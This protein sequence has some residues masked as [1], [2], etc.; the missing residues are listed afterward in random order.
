MDIIPLKH[1]SI[2]GNTNILFAVDEKSAYV[3]CVGIKSKGRKTLAAAMIEIIHTFNAYGH[4]VTKIISDDESC[5]HATEK[6]MAPLGIEL[7][8]TPAGFHQ[9]RAKRYIQTLKARK[10]AILASLSYQLPDKLEA[11]AYL[12]AM[13]SMNIVVNTVSGIHT[14]YQLV[15]RRKPFIPQF[16]FGQTGV[17][18]SRRKDTPDQRGEWGLFLSFGSSPRYLRCYIPVRDNVY[19]RSTFDPHPNYP[20]EWKF[21][22]R[23]SLPSS[24][25][26][27]PIIYPLNNISSPNTII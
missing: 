16:H 22:E 17:F 3:S 9:K 4:R 26:T 14:P 25:Q 21:K 2:G 5:F 13:H 18:H 23:L 10:R 19:S 6:D 27:L 24:K 12:A 8:S 7:S 1:E 11:E 20:K 15:T